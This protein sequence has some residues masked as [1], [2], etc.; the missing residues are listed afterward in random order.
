MPKRFSS[1]KEDAIGRNRRHAYV[2]MQAHRRCVSATMNTMIRPFVDC[3]IIFRAP[4]ISSLAAASLLAVTD[5]MAEA[6]RIFSLT[7]E[8]PLR[9]VDPVPAG[10]VAGMAEFA[11]KARPGE[12]FVLQ[13][14]VVAGSEALG[15]LRLIFSDLASGSDIIPSGQIECLNLGGFG[16]DGKPL[17]KDLILPPQRTQPL[18][19]GI[20]V[21]ESANGTYSGTARL[22]AGG[23]V[24]GS[25]SV[26]IQVEG[27]PVA[28]HG[29]DEAANL[30]R[31]RWLISTVGSEATVTSPFTNVE[32][33]GRSVRVLGR[34]LEVGPGGLPSRITSFF[35][36]ANTEIL[37]SGWAM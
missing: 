17:R 1:A 18:W 34:E 23:S 4:A 9:R 36:D 2:S 27:E 16:N 31:L 22:D 28:N 5:A 20:Q 25:Y 8:E 15:P 37:A 24:V 19:C 35:N 13:L 7:R 12:Y 11:G 6:P 29:D 26:R 32:V 33:S 3:F 30:S 10:A 21:P 14:G